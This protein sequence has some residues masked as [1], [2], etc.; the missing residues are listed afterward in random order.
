MKKH[1]ILIMKTQ[2]SNRMKYFSIGFVCVF[3]T[4]NITVESFSQNKASDWFNAGISSFSTEEKIQ[5][6]KKAIQL[7]PNIIEA[8][9]H[10]GLAYNI[11]GMYAEAEL[12][13]NKAYFKNPY[14]LN[15]ELK[16]NLLFEL[17]KL[18]ANGGK[19][20]KARAALLGAKELSENKNRGRICYE[21]GQVYLKNGQIEKAV[22]EFYEGKRLLPQNAKLFVDL[23]SLAESKKTLTEKYKQCNS[24]LISERYNEAIDLL[25]EIIQIDPEFKDVQQKLNDAQSAL[26]QTNLIKKLMNLHNLARQMDNS[27]KVEEAV[28]LLSQ[29][30]AIDPNFKDSQIRLQELRS[31]LAEKSR[32]SL[33][34]D[35]QQKKRD[36]ELKSLATKDAKEIENKEVVAKRPI[37]SAKTERPK[38]S[39]PNDIEKESKIAVVKKTESDSNLIVTDIETLYQKGL[40]ALH[41]GDWQQAVSA[42]E[43]IQLLD[44]EYKDLRN[45][46]ADARF[47]LIK[48]QIVK[49][50]KSSSNG[51][52]TFLVVGS[53]ISVIFLPILGLL[54]LSPVTRAKILFLQ[55]KYDR[56]ATIYEKKLL[57]NPGTIKL[58]ALLANIYLLTNRSDA[59]ALKVFEMIL[60]LNIFTDRRNEINSIMA[61]QS[62]IQGRT[63]ANAIQIMER[64]LDTK[65]INLNSNNNV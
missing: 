23:I 28:S 47:N 14:A 42:F 55:G 21:L 50:Q 22:D 19:I 62:Q 24:L 5:A 65:M 3:L 4:L 17:G 51:N 35:S 48:S 56:A 54:I 8:Y 63:D 64:E 34:K 58:Y 39:R 61:K 57:K 37:A 59:K 7:D 43:K 2:L 18:Y 44:T 60:K 49:N 9:Y 10:L 27:G 15:N 36:T 16:T 13:F 31:E 46:L 32:I 30:V 53:T 38:K 29:I 20:E 11:K 45:N 33:K 25:N 41:N 12:T 52:S 40:F 1:T 26:K 6:F